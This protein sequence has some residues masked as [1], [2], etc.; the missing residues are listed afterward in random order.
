[1]NNMID[2]LKQHFHTEWAAM[3][4]QDWIG[5]VMTVVVFLVMVALYIFVFMPSNKDKLEAHRYIPL[6]EDQQQNGDLDFRR[7]NRE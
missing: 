4:L 1:M 3:T 6:E 5:V 2:N 7:A